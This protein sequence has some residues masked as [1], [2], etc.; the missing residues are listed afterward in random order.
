MSKA[1]PDRAPPISSQA[2][3]DEPGIGL[4][5]RRDLAIPLVVEGHDSPDS[6]QPVTMGI[7]LPVGTLWRPEELELIGPTG[8]PVPLQMIPLAR[9][10]D[11]SI[12]WLLADFLLGPPARNAPWILRRSN[13]GGLLSHQDMLRIR[14][15][16]QAVAVETGVATFH[17]GPATELP[18]LVRV[19]GRDGVD[20][21][22][23]RLI[24]TDRTG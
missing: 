1:E 2:S 18:G 17:I 15:S 11:G 3:F 6:G 9:W 10:S 8:R 23:I 21:G 5:P 12:K 7:P 14:E 22:S 20:L 24:L 4:T 13:E 16:P 19:G